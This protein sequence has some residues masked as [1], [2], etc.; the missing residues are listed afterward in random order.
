MLNTLITYIVEKKL[1]TPKDKILLALSGGID[2][3]VLTHLLQQCPQLYQQMAIAHCNFQLRGDDSN[4]DEAFV[5]AL[6]EQYTVPCFVTRFDTSTLAHTQKGSIQMIARQLRYDW[7]ETICQQEGYDYVVTA[8][9]QGDLTETVLL[10]LVRGTGI[11]GLHGIQKKQGKIIRPLLFANKA[12]ITNYATKQQ[13]Q[14]RE[15]ASNQEN[16]YYRNRL[17]NEVVPILKGMN[18]NLDHTLAQSIEKISA[19]ERFFEKAL[20]NIEARALTRKKGDGKGQEKDVF[21]LHLDQLEDVDEPLIV[22][23]E[24]LRKFGFSYV[25]VKAIY[26]SLDQI[27]GKQFFSSTHTLVKDRR[28]LVI[29]PKK[30]T[31]IVEQVL[32]EE[33]PLGETYRQENLGLSLQRISLDDHFKIPRNAEIACLDWKKLTLPLRIRPW[34]QGDWFKPLGMN[35]RKK[36]SDFLIDQKVP[37][38]LKTQVN[39]VLSGE[40]I[41]WVVGLRIDHRFK[42]ADDTTEALII[43]LA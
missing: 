38:N 22:F 34:Q 29:T 17:R 39:V 31:S 20:K 36:L 19:V 13:L 28:Q 41:V 40:D 12:T 16:K 10:N 24:M 9:H 35:R 27:S 43:S 2:S 18:P 42:V 1:F 21:F 25:Q 4:Q 30:T 8:H 14:W 33:L 7:F 6:A 37:L 26:E 23:F 3:V 15:D 5:R 11:A 32:V